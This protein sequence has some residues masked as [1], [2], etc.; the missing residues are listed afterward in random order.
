MHTPPDLTK[1]LPQCTSGPADAYAH[2]QRWLG[3]VRRGRIG[4]GSGTLPEWAE[5]VLRNEAVLRRAAGCRG[6]RA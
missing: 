1:P 6:E 2:Q 3:H 4:G 5:R